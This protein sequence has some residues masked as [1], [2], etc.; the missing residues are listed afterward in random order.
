MLD[1]NIEKAVDW[2]MGPGKDSSWKDKGSLILDKETILKNFGIKTMVNGRRTV[3]G[4]AL[5]DAINAYTGEEIRQIDENFYL[6][7]GGFWI[8]FD[9]F[10]DP[11]EENEQ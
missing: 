1:T 5:F 11:E 9:P 7:N 8:H 2:V 6:E 3:E 4:D 10:Y